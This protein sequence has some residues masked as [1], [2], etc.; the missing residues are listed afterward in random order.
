MEVVEIK[1]QQMLMMSVLGETE[2][3]E[4]NLAPD[5]LLTEDDVDRYF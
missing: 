5:F 4:G 2:A 3:A 1:T